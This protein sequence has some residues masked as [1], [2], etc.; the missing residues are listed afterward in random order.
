M[1]KCPFN[2]FKS[3]NLFCAWYVKSRKECAIF[4]MCEA[5]NEDK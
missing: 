5:P 2:N 4:L 1:K 3:C